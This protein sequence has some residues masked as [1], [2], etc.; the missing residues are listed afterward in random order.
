MTSVHQAGAARRWTAVTASAGKKARRRG[1][2]EEIRVT[3]R[4]DTPV[5]GAITVPRLDDA[6]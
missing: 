3:A 1:P 6:A 5:N 2:P 4:G